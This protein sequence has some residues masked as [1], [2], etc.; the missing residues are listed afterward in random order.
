MTPQVRRTFEADGGFPVQP[1]VPE[2][3]K[4]DG[5][6][7]GRPGPAGPRAQLGSALVDTGFLQIQYQENQ[8]ATRERKRSHENKTKYRNKRKIKAQIRKA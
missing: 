4:G 8:T 6:P 2:V 3:E 7:A 1:Q 5:W